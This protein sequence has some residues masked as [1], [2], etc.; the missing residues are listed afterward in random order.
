MKISPVI[1]GERDPRKKYHFVAS[2][3]RKFELKRN[4]SMKYTKPH[5]LSTVDA[6]VAIQNGTGVAHAKGN[7]VKEDNSDQFSTTGVYPADE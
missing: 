5:V 7:I 3:A 6:H 4:T 1:K 2:D